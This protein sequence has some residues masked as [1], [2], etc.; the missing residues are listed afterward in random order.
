MICKESEDCSGTSS[1]GTSFMSQETEEKMPK[2]VE[3]S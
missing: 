3:N 2:T 1:D